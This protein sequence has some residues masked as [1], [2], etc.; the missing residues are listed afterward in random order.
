MK[1]MAKTVM[2]EETI[3]TR[4]ADTEY[5][6]EE[7]TV[8]AAKTKVTDVAADASILGTDLFNDLF[9]FE[10]VSFDE[11]A[12][13][14]K[15]HANQFDE[16]RADYEDLRLPC[17]ATTDSAGY[18]FYAPR[19]YKIT[20]GTQI[21][22]PTGIRFVVNHKK[23]ERLAGQI[24]EDSHFMHNLIPL[25]AVIHDLFQN[26]GLHLDILPRS[27]I[28]RRS[29]MR[30]SNTVGLIDADYYKSDNE[31]HIFICLYLPSDTTSMIPGDSSTSRERGLL[32]EKGTAFAQGVV[33]FHLKH[34]EFTNNAI[35]NGGLGSTS[36][37]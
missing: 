2:T 11:F 33:G 12:K 10:K 23:I 15:Y 6:T 20:P 1:E 31:G 37:K 34:P 5:S 32:I 29:L 7:M 28:G 17:A 19:T 27:G 21:M 36:T 14:M 3:R 13:D 35:R 16:A 4:S 26:I 22:I 25:M 18:D 8:T 24:T 9:H 30:I